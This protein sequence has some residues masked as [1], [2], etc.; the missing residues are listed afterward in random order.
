MEYKGTAQY[1]EDLVSN[2]EES[3]YRIWLHV[4]N[5]AG[6]RKLVLSPDTDVYHV[7]MPLIQDTNLE[8]FIQLNQ[9]T[10]QELHFL[11]LGALL[12]A[13]CNDPDLSN[14]ERNDI[15]SSMQAVF[16][17]TGCDFVSFFQGH[18]KASF[19]N[20]LFEYSGFISANS[21]NAPG[22][23]ASTDHNGLLAFFRLVGC[24]YFRK[25]KSAFQPTYLTPIAIFLSLQN[26]SLAPAEHHSAWLELMRERLWSKINYEEEMIPSDGALERHWKRSQWI[27]SVWKQATSHLIV[28]PPLVGNGWIQPDPKTLSIDWDSKNNI[29]H[30]RSRVALITK[31]C[32]CRTGCR[33]GRCGCKKKGRE[34]NVGCTCENCC[35]SQLTSNT[36]VD[37]EVLETIESTLTDSDLEDEV[38]EI[39]Y[40]VFGPSEAILA[41]ICTSSDSEYS[42]SDFEYSSSDNDLSSDSESEV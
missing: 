13:F 3:D 7:G 14:L 12:T 33:T 42:S 5:S 28:Y 39:M 36:H 24:A 20:T 31:G 35:N 16:V 30:I 21:G 27:L 41:D 6:I 9:R 23:L 4:L 2:A 38:D 15:A 1:N 37:L 40:R 10:S 17:S 22:T 8:V 19:L 25:H 32:K 18:G 11:N 29:Q 34:C 26:E